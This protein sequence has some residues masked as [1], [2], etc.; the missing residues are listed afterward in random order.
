MCIHIGCQA[1]LPRCP[2]PR[3]MGLTLENAYQRKKA[4]R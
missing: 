4:V 2:G 3:Y 1:V